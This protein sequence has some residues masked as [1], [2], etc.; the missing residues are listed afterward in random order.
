M[1]TLILLPLLSLLSQATILDTPDV[2]TKILVSCIRSACEVNTI[3]IDKTLKEY[4]VIYYS[5]LDLLAPLNKEFYKT[6]SQGT[7]YSRVRY[8]VTCVEPENMDEICKVDIKPYNM[9]TSI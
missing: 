7:M 4:K 1:K 2:K 5:D 3:S 6:L 8:R 9:S